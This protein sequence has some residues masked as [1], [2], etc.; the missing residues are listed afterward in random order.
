MLLATIQTGSFSKAAEACNCSQP[1]ITQAMNALEG[2]LN[3]KIL[4]RSH[5][6]VTLTS[7]GEKLLPAIL[8]ADYAIR[9]VIKAAEALNKKTDNVIRIGSFA[10][11]ANTWLPPLLAGFKKQNPDVEYEMAIAT[12]DLESYMR[13]GE[14]DI[15]FT[16]NLRNKS[17]R[18]HALSDED[19]SFVVNTNTYDGPLE[20]IDVK[21]IEKY[22]FIMITNDMKEHLID[23]KPKQIIPLFS[24]SDDI[25]VNMVAQELG[26]TIVPK[27]SMPDNLPDNVVIVPTNPPLK[28]TV[29][30]AVPNRPTELTNLLVQYVKKHYK[31]YTK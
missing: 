7:D 13:N 15:S 18:F 8:D 14:T 31:P 27:L 11:I 28:R 12:N 29:G 10:S 17:F 26:T 19:M 9:N 21:D 2:E 25:A 23:L 22:P 1:A 6:G 20:E 16:D 3:V 4:N 30:M 5:S 24:D